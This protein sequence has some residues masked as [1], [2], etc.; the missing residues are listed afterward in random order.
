MGK[1]TLK[2]R[3]KGKLSTEKPTFEKLST[4]LR[5]IATLTDATRRD[6][7]K[8]ASSRKKVDKVDFD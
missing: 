1:F 4:R 2:I 3:I 5:L 7:K 6:A 8:V